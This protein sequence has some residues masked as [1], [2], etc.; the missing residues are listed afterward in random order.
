MSGRRIRTYTERK[1]RLGRKGSR[2]R[3]TLESKEN[4]GLQVLSKSVSAGFRVRL[5]IRNDRRLTF[6]HTYVHTYISLLSVR[7]IHSLSRTINVRII[8][9]GRSFFFFFFALP[10]ARDYLRFCRIFARAQRLSGQT[11]ANSAADN[12]PLYLP[13]AYRIPR[14]RASRGNLILKFEKLRLL[15]LPSFGLGERERERRERERAGSVVATARC[16]TF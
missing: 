14:V 15:Q 11:R 3:E 6:I 10:R 16:E 12:R 8:S 13:A 5:C 9:D 7:T 1:K 4:V 2:K